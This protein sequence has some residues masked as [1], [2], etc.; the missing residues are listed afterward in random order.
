MCGLAAAQPVRPAAPTSPDSA[1]GAA[2]RDSAA[3]GV[4]RL[5]AVTVT[6]SR[7]VGSV[8]ALPDVRGA[9]LFTGKK[10]QVLLLDSLTANRAQN[11]SREVLG[12]IPGANFSETEGAG[13]P[14]NGIGW[15]GLDPVQSVELNVRQDGVGIAA[16]A[17]G[18]PET[19]YLPPLEA[20][21]RVEVVRG[22]GSLQF[23]PQVGGVINYVL[24][25]GA[26][27][28]PPRVA[29]RQTVGSYGLSTTYGDVSGGAGRW[30]Y[31]AYAQ[32]RAQD[33]SR[34]H[35]DLRQL[36][37]AGRLGYAAAGPAGAPALRLTLDYSLLRNRI[38]M[39]G[40]LGNEAFDA[41]PWQS[42]RA[43]N[44]LTSPWNVA[45]LTADWRLG[46]FTRL[47]TTVSGMSS[48]RALV[49]RNE[50]GGADAPDAVDPATGLPVPR[51]VE[52][53]AFR[54]VTLESRLLTTY[55]LLGGYHTLA[56][57]V[58]AYRGVM[59]RDEGG[60]GTQGGGFNLALAP[61]TTYA[62]QY[63]FATSNAALFAENAFRLGDRFTVT[64]GARLEWLRSTGAGHAP[65]PAGDDSA[66]SFGPK[67]RAVPLAGVG[68]QWRTSATTNAYANVTGAYRP[69][70]YST[71]VPFGSAVRVAPNLRDARATSADAG[72]RGTW[73]DV[74]TFDVGAFRMVYR[75]RIGLVT[76]ADADGTIYTERR[77]VAKSLHCGVES[78][79]ELRP[80]NRLLRVG[81]AAGIFGVYDSFAYVRATYVGGEFA[82]NAVEYAPR[83]VDRLGLTWSRG[84]VN[85]TLQLSTVTRQFGDANNTVASY[86]ASVGLV[87]AYQLL[88]WSGSWRVGPRAAVNFGV[89]NAGNVAYFT[90]RTAEY[91]GPGILP[92][93]GRSVYLGLAYATAPG[94]AR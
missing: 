16:D 30:T 82:G 49:W 45:A 44:W 56:A 1:R 26:P 62:S 89:N 53:E 42:L 63:R 5:T 18:Y 51:E 22:A 8:A 87:P 52:R 68:A 61:G 3:R 32:G 27:N 54:N 20:V 94:R 11:V 60:T 31:F 73:R 35:G 92:G 21:S 4:T 47:V 69:V 6:G 13:F 77:N 81:D 66:V 75:D 86:D 85:A 78:F 90:R 43:R 23:G 74:V 64:P 37:A 84:P 41:D 80:L 17:F 76:A 36:S 28:T 79:V 50:D 10:T 55:R 72:L 65:N 38:H 25:E 83:V 33:G 70:D 48:A 58:R 2:R 14:A 34:P 46:T 29:A 67:S 7:P 19:Y 91:P 59:D 88:D 15:R 12:R 24:R 39:P 9:V 71:L 93:Q 57:G 40:G